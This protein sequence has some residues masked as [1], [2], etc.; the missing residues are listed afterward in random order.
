[1]PHLTSC[2]ELTAWGDPVGSHT[3]IPVPKVLAWSAD[4]SNPV[5]A[6]YII[7]EKAPGIQLFKIWDDITELD[8]LNLIKGLIQFESQFSAIRFPAY[9]SLYFRDSTLKASERILLDTSVDPNGLFCVGPA[10]GLAWTDGLSPAD[11]RPD[12]DA[13]PCE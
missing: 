12:L 6:E 8:R 10:C 3:T 9:G 11:I 5:G 13:G 4:T 2:S 1:M 7:M